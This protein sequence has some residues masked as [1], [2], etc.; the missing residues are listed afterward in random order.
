M[1][2]FCDLST[3]RSEKT[4]SEMFSK[5]SAKNTVTAGFLTVL[6]PDFPKNPAKNTAHA[7]FSARFLSQ[8]F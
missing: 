1:E 2:R 5:T 7:R 6:L 8:W 3:L 4:E